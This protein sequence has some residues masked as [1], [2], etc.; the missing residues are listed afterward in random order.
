VIVE[1]VLRLFWLTVNARLSFAF[2]TFFFVPPFEG[3]TLPVTWMFSGS[4]AV[5]ADAGAATASVAARAIAG[6]TNFFNFSSSGGDGAG[7]R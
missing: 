2:L 4:G 3:V 6:A 7:H 1:T 5:C